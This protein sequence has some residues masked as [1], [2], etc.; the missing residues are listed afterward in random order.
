MEVELYDGTVLEF[1]D[2]TADEVINRV[3]KRETNKIRVSA[4]KTKE[5]AEY[6]TKSPEYQAKY[7]AKP[8]GLAQLG[9]GLGLAGRYAL[10]G[11]GQTADIF[12]EPVRRLVTD[13]LLGAAGF[14]G[15]MPTSQAASEVSDFAGLPSPET[16]GERTV[17]EASRILAGGGGLGGL[18]KG[19]AKVTSGVT[20][21]V[22]ESL[23]AN[24]GS[25]AAS[26][27][28]AGAAGGY[29]REETQD[30]L[31]QFGASLLGGVAA[32]F[33]LAGLQNAGRSVANS[34]QKA[35]APKDIEGILRV[36][37]QRAGI[38]WQALSAE[39]RAALVKDAEK[40]V[41]SG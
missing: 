21:Q 26:A 34:I 16:P 20:N 33:G 28:G 6:D 40:A 13:P 24:Q 9:R 14:K 22:M 38:D 7:G 18:A 25:Q 29:V 39:A 36:E 27:V 37:L 2:D 15:G 1:P 17:G 11:L 30:P 35:V 10:E 3:A 5:P 31:A 8:G 12:T 19:G 32:P 4:R 23:A 41:Y